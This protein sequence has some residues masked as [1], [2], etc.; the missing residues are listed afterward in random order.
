MEEFALSLRSSLG[1]QHHLSLV[2][3]SRC[4]LSHEFHPTAVMHTLEQPGLL[5]ISAES[6]TVY[7]MVLS[8]RQSNSCVEQSNVQETTEEFLCALPHPT[9][10]FF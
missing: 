2:S 7:Y 3:V 5:L 1:L 9:P 4:D 10:L 6:G 8:N